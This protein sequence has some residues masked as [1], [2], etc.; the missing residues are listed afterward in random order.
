MISY[1]KE[2]T[3]FGSFDDPLEFVIFPDVCLKLHNFSSG[4]RTFVIMIN[5]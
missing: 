2:K 3:Y 1:F 5:H 4:R